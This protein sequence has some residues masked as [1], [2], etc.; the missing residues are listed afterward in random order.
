MVIMFA[1]AVAFPLVGISLVVVWLLDRLLLS[2][3]TRQTETA[4]PS[5]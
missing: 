1:L 5:S 3:L 4:S 2:R